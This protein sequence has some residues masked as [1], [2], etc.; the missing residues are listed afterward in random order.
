MADEQVK[1]LTP[2]AREAI[3]SYLGKKVTRYA[4]IFGIVNVLALG[5]ILLGAFNQAATTVNKRLADAKVDIDELNRKSGELDQKLKG[6]N[7][8][9]P[10]LEDK[11][12]AI[13][14]TNIDEIGELAQKLKSAVGSLDAN[15]LK[16][17]DLLNQ[18]VIEQG[19][20]SIGGAENLLAPNGCVADRGIVNGRVNFGKS[21]TE[22]P[23]VMVGFTYF[24]IYTETPIR[25]NLKVVS[26][27]SS[28]FTYTF[29]TWCDTRVTGANAD[30]IAI[31]H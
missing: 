11:I 23:S 15:D 13:N 19:T 16:A 22:T 10:T 20:I 5:G 7:E 24:D 27:D 3:D 31:G 9:I 18:P 14:D 1:G 21:F 17:L 30:W 29:V 28:G 4:T 12:K 6:I 26:I 2:E 25:L 8:Q